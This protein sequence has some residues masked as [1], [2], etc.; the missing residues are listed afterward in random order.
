MSSFI[1]RAK[2]FA[3]KG[4]SSYDRPLVYNASIKLPTTRIVTPSVTN[5]SLIKVKAY[6]KVNKSINTYNKTKL[7]KQY[8][9]SNIVTNTFLWRFSNGYWLS[10]GNKDSD[11]YAIQNDNVCEESFN[12]MIIN[13][14][15]KAKIVHNN[16]TIIMP[17]SANCMNCVVN[18]AGV[19]IRVGLTNPLR[20]DGDYIDKVMIVDEDNL[21]LINHVIHE[22]IWDK[23]KIAD[24]YTKLLHSMYEVNVRQSS[25]KIQDKINTQGILFKAMNHEIGSL[26]VQETL[27]MDKNDDCSVLVVNNKIVAISYDSDWE[28][29]NAM[30]D[31][32]KK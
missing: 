29:I 5:Q 19:S 20:Y 4:F 15:L 9:D 25:A 14:N 24:F 22:A 17:V 30:C 11:Y 18:K 27:I 32:M 2:L 12:L 1:A 28:N 16:K 3:P 8:C 6:N 13:N 23:K 31:K 21:N 10:H 26:V 7:F